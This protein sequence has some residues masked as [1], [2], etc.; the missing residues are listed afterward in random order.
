MID[1][2]DVTPRNAAMIRTLLSLLLLFSLATAAKAQESKPADFFPLMAWDGPPNDLAVLK[3]M[4]DCGLTVAGFVPPAALDNCQAAGLK[5]IVSDPRVGGYDWTNVDAEKAKKQVTE[6]VEQVKSHPAVYGYYLRDEP[7][8]NFFPGLATVANVVKEHHSGVWPYINLFPNYAD[9][10]QLGAKSYEEYLEKFIETCKPPIL[11]YD[12]YT[13]YEGGGH[14]D[15]YFENLEQMRR[16]ALKHSLPFWNIIQ[17][18]G[19]LNFRETSA[20]DLRW[21]V[22][23]SL[24]YGARGIAYFKYFSAPTGNFRQAPIDHFGH[25]TPAWEAMRQINLQVAQ[26]AP[27]LLKLKS[28]RVY[29]FGETPKGCS[30]PDD[31]S[32]VKGIGGNVVVGDFTHEDGSRYVLIVNKDF[33]GSIVCGPQYRKQP[34]KIEH[35]SQYHGSLGSFVGE[36]CWLAPGQGVLL[37]LTF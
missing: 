17:S 26:L 12:H 13:L 6:L 4:K 20:A 29:H 23:T 35:V 15:R 27:T 9:A 33:K 11:S 10:G 18:T 8:S 16:V 21:Q 25:K 36:D 5:G 2:L 24:A 7:T 30:G 22:Y 34:S 3:E 19:C 28:D 37:K 14:G 32:L 1:N 31:D